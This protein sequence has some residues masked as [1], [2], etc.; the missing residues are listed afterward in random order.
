MNI[1]TKLP[2]PL[3]VFLGA[4]SL[5]F[6]GLIVKSFEGA[7]LWQILFWRS[8]FF[9]LTILTFLIISYKKKTFKSFYDSGLP[10]FFGGII[11]SFGFCGYVFAMY[12]TTVANTNFIISLQIL[13]LAVFGYFF[14]KE[15]ISAATLASIILA[16]T[17]VL[18]MV[19]NSLTPGELSGNLAAFTMPIT[20]AILIMIVRKYPTVD[21]VPAQFVAGVC[22]CIIGFLLSTK[23]MISPNDIFLGFLAGFFQVGFGFIFITI[24]ARTTPSAMVGIIMLSESVLGPVWAFLFVSE[25]PSIFGLVGGAIILFAVLLQFYSLLMKNK[26]TISN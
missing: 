4:L 22:S 10:G 6:G 12:N 18:V 1:I 8:L 16:I 26:K 7:T 5:S 20:F 9:S 21:M 14:L 17:G 19:G 25:R 24:G 15:K 11:L 3:L 13:F 2:G 23:L